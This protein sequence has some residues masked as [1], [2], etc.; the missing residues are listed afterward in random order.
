MRIKSSKEQP[1]TNMVLQ[2]TAVLSLCFCLLTG[3]GS[4]P[5]PVEQPPQQAET[6]IP[7]KT[8]TPAEKEETPAYRDDLVTTEIKEDYEYTASRYNGATGQ[9]EQCMETSHY[10]IPKINM[11]SDG[12]QRINTELYE[13]LNSMI[14][15]AESASGQ[16]PIYSGIDYRWYASGDILSLVVETTYSFDPEAKT[17]MV[18]NLSISEGTQL[19]NSEVYAAAGYTEEA[20]LQIARD[21][22]E[23]DFLA[24]WD[25][26]NDVNFENS[27]FVDS[28]NELLQKTTAPENVQQSMPYINGSGQLCIIAQIYSMA[29][30]GSYWRDFEVNSTD[31]SASTPSSVADCYKAELS[32]YQNSS[33]K[34][35]LY[36]I[37]KDGTAELIIKQSGSRYSV[38]SFEN[39]ECKSCGDI[40]S[41]YG[42][43]FEY[44]GNGIISHDGGMGSNH[45]EYISLYTLSDG[46]MSSAENI[47]STESLTYEEI[48]NKCDEYT[49]LNFYPINDYTPFG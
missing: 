27:Y 44:D 49:Q 33:K 5:A 38:S 24:P 23:A 48:S 7:E 41:D 45:L 40:Y 47:A 9:V 43:F 1:M 12:A 20:Y 21:T 29:G 39:G 25:M 37:D 30:A 19:S 4:T 34:Y 2:I 31:E 18:Y 10:K 26:E 13:T 15:E 35:T 22:M 28:F 32:N 17:Y 36:D 16:S 46:E 42:R 11:E 8:Q 6:Q 3:C 14:Q